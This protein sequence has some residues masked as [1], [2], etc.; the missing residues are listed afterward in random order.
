M[1]QFHQ[2]NSS[3][4]QQQAY[5]TGPFVPEYN[6]PAY[7]MRGM[8][9]AVAMP[10]VPY[11]LPP[12]PVPAYHAAGLP[13]ADGWQ[14]GE[15]E[16]VA[17]LAQ[18]IES[19]LVLNPQQQQMMG[20][21]GQGQYYGNPQQ[22]G[23]PPGTYGYGYAPP[24]PGL[25]GQQQPM[26][27]QQHMGPQGMGGHPHQMLNGNGP[28]GHA[29]SGPGNH[30]QQGGGMGGPQRD[31]GKGRGQGRGGGHMQDQRQLGP[32]QQGQQ[33]QQ[34]QR[35]KKVQRGLEDNVKRTVYISYIDQQVGGVGSAFL[36][37]SAAVLELLSGKQIEQGLLACMFCK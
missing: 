25:R 14:G 27:H 10:Y 20:A 16:N 26:M 34:Q 33:G 4:Q 6:A 8:P 11:G 31:G 5:L 22:R 13:P 18:G 19:N 30:H 36:Q 23:P 37:A 3:N 28:Y 9:T 32:G 24:A 35:R 17:N 1:A 7:G 2:G 21:P 12:A 15:Q 29:G